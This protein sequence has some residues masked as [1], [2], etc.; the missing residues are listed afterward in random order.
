MD[1]HPAAPGWGCVRG[2]HNF[3]AQLRMDNLH[4]NDI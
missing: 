1:V 4:S 3:P 2:S